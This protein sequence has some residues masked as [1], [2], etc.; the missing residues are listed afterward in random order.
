[1]PRHP[2][3]PTSPPSTPTSPPEAAPDGAPAR[4]G[5]AR[6][7]PEGLLQRRGE[8]CD[9]VEER[10]RG[11]LPVPL[12]E[13]QLAACIAITLLDRAHLLHER[14]APHEQHHLGVE[15]ERTDVHV[16]RAD[17]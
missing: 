12:L 15:A 3:T 2:S 16:A 13:G 14:G 9:A 5:G 1:M 11:G 7:V 6:I 8:A 10:R 17:H 4:A